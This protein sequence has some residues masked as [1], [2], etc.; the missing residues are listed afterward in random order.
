MCPGFFFRKKIPIVISQAASSSGLGHVLSRGISK[1]YSSTL[2]L[3][4]K[5]FNLG[6]TVSFCLSARSVNE[7]KGFLV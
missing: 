4:P 5:P 1:V 2:Q 3:L 7:E 6:F